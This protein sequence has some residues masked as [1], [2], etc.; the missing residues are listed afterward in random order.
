[1]PLNHSYHIHNEAGGGGV[2][3]TVEAI[4]AFA[5][6]HGPGAYVV[7]VLSPDSLPGSHVLASAWGKVIHHLDGKVVIYIGREQVH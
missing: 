5:R 4:G 6:D 1:M 7:D 3:Q 2:V